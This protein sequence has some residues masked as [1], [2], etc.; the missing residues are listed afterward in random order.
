MAAFYDI[1]SDPNTGDL[2]IQG[3]DFAIGLSDTQHIQDLVLS[4]I[5]TWKEFP[6]IGVGLK[7]YQGSAGKEQSIEQAIQ[8]QL[9]ADGYDASQV[10]ISTAPDG[11]FNIYT[12]ATRN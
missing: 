7:Q 2:L 8:L 10:T 5:G 6:S 11:T 4:F 3:N 12:N 9:S 1:L